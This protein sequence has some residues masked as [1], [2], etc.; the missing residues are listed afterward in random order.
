MGE[1]AAGSNDERICK[2]CGNGC[3]ECV[4]ERLCSAC[5][6]DKFLNANDPGMCVTNCTLLPADFSTANHMYFLNTTSNAC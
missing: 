4:D 2:P 6:T 1:I 3:A 5:D